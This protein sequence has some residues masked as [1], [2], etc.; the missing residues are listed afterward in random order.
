[1]FATAL[2]EDPAAAAAILADA[3]EE[4][5]RALGELRDLAH[6]IY[7][8]VLTSDGLRAA[9]EEALGDSGLSARLECGGLGR[10]SPELEAAVYFCCLEALQNIA[11]YAEASQ[12]TVTLTGDGDELCF[13]VTDDGRGFDCDTTT[14]GMGLQNMADRLDA[15]GGDLT[16]E[17]APGR[18]TTVA[19]S[20]PTAPLEA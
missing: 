4:S 12:V 7:P 17:S 16:V 15:V 19:G 5:K 18:G 10:H 2:G 20:I 1:M 14:R 6:G 11:K 9:L 8:Q 13:R 3:R